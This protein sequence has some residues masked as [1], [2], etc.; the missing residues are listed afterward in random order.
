MFTSPCCLNFFIF[1]PQDCHGILSWKTSSWKNWGTRN[2]SVKLLS[3]D[4]TKQR[5]ETVLRASFYTTMAQ[6]FSTDGC[7]EW[8]LLFNGKQCTRP[9][10]IF[11]VVLRHKG[12]S[13]WYVVPTVL[14]GFCE[15]TTDGGFHPGLVVVSAHV[16]SCSTTRG[17]AHTGKPHYGTVTSSFVV[18]EYCKN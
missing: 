11:T 14:T 6:G 7:S 13:V 17:D 9:N 4:Y 10:P 16:R 1:I 8:Y 5:A 15:A 18:E 2:N 12:E 3:I